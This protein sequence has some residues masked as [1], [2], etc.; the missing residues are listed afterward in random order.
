VPRPALPAIARNVAPR[1][2]GDDRRPRRPR[3]MKPAL[4]EAIRLLVCGECK[5]QQAAAARVGLHPQRLSEAFAKPEIQAFIAREARATI[6][7][8]QLPATATLVRLLDANSEHVAAQV[9]ERL[10]AINGIK[11]D[12]TSRVAVS[13]DI[14]AGYVIDL[15]PGAE[16]PKAIN[17][18]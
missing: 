9:A 8:A 17:E 2:S 4:R 16:S 3:S 6:G 18:S 12:D 5:T 14:R 15:R 7:A 11:P 10:L 13:V 1:A